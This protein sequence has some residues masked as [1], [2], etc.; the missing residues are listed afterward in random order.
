VVEPA[1]DKGAGVSVDGHFVTI[2]GGH[3]HFGA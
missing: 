3:L 2:P 1:G